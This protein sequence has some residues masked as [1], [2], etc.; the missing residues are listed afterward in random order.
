[1]L[2][3][4]NV[5]LCEVDGE[6]LIVEPNVIVLLPVF[7]E[8]SALNNTGPW[9]LILLPILPLAGP[10]IVPLIVKVASDDVVIPTP[11]FNVIAEPEAVYKLL[12]LGK[13]LGKVEFEKDCALAVSPTVTWFAVKFNPVIVFDEG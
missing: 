5:K 11:L 1:V 8:V 6:L 7:N 9:K 13:V 10:V 2:L 12:L 3:L 4:V